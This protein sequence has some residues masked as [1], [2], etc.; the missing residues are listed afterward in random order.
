MRS[1]IFFGLYA[2]LKSFNFLKNLSAPY[3][4]ILVV[5]IDLGLMFC[6]TQHT[7]IYQNVLVGLDGYRS[8]E[9]GGVTCSKVSV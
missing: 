3:V 9:P 1:T 8:Q 6:G 5:L 7:K 4:L 2:H